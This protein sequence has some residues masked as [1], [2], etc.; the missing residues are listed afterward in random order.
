MEDE[1]N[2]QDYLIEILGLAVLIAVLAI[3]TF[4]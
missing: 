2:R 1:E 4:G 3:L